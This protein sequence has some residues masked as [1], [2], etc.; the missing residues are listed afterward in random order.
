MSVAFAFALKYWREIAVGVL[1]LMLVSGVIYIRSVFTERDGLV[2]DKAALQKQVDDAASVQE[3]AGKIDDAV[4][5]IKIRSN[6]N[7]SRIESEESPQFVDT[8]PLSF[9]PG[10]L[11]KPFSL[12]S[13]EAQGGTGPTHEAGGALPAGEPAGG[14]LPDRS[15]AP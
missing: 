10:G 15:R 2:R 1:T 7:V 13:S 11:L 6:T 9:I 14:V 3:L 5:E 8:R 12:Y 4:A